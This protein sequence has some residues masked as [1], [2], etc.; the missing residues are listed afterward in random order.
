MSTNLTVNKVKEFYDVV[1]HQYQTGAKLDGTTMVMHGVEGDSV[2]FPKMNKGTGVA[3]GTGQ[4]NIVEGAGSKLMNIG[5]SNVSATLVG[6]V[7]PELT[8]IFDQAEVNYNEQKALANVIVKAMGRRKDQTV[9]SALGATSGN[10]SI[11]IGSTGLTIAKILAAKA[12]L[13]DAGVDMDDRH[14]AISAVGLQQLLQ[15]T[16]VTSI[17]YGNVKAL[18]NG[19]VDTF[20]GF[21][22]HLIETRAEGGLPLSTND[23]TCFAWHMDAIGLGISIEP[24]M[25]VNYL[26]EYT[27]TLA[28][29]MLAMG[30][31]T[32]ENTGVVD[33]HI[34]ESV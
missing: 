27:S 26:P 15:T 2:Q 20:V 13:D 14:L 30:A 19:E 9:L 16:Q 25:E 17:D 18:V 1:K 31:I 7:F 24:K 34:D 8:D 32:I 11:A 3:R 23:R 29:G 4:V 21:K 10:T 6:Y 22:I 33:I 5:Q 28:N 12:A